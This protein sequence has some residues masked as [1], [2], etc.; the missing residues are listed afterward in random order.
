MTLGGDMRA[1]H[2]AFADQPRGTRW[3]IRGRSWLCP[4][5]VVAREVPVSGRILDIG[6]G[7]G[8]F[9]ALLASGSS[10]RSIVGVDPSEGKIAVARG[11]TKTLPTISY[12]QGSVLDL[13]DGPYDA[14]TIL[15][16]LYLL[17]DELKRRILAHART[18]I[19][20]DGVFLLKTNDTH[21]RWK[22]GV[23]RLEEW[24]MVKLLRYTFGGELHFR[25]S[26]Q[27]LQM[28]D[29][30]GFSAEVRRVD[31]WRPVPHRLFVCRPK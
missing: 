11:T 24:L 4:M 3:F 6:C 13:N 17:P 16:V 31:G 20:D 19:K 23:V 8:L 9:P 21:P 27:Y 25:S 22:F 10:Q 29:E 1:A 18:L 7:H 5:T 30:A 14:I 28:L 26:E 15:D 12:I 2:R